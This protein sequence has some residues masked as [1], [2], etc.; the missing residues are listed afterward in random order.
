L[1]SHTKSPFLE[2]KKLKQ[3]QEAAATLAKNPQKT[4]NK[5]QPTPGGCSLLRKH[6]QQQQTNTRR[7]TSEV[8]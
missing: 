4:I 3:P 5:Q 8:E 6:H 1:N 2:T 7:T